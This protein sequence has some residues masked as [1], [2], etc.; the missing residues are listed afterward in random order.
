VINTART[1]IDTM[2]VAAIV[3]QE[4]L[5]LEPDL[6]LYEGANDF[7]PRPQLELAAQR[8][9]WS[10]PPAMRSSRTEGFSA[11]A[12][13]LHAF[14]ARLERRDGS[15]PRKPAYPIQWPAEVDEW[16]PDVTQSAL[17]MNLKSVLDRFDAMRT[18]TDKTGG[19]FGVASPVRMVR[20]GLK[21]TLP[22]DETLY[23][24]LNSYYPLTY[25]QVKRLSDFQQRVFR[26]YAARYDLLYLDSAAMYPLD[27]QLFADAV[28]MTPA[29]LRLKAWI[30]LQL[31]IPWL[32]RE[33]D[34]GHLPRPMQHPQAVH[35]AFASTSYP[36]VSKAEILASCH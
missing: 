26:A 35:P 28:H 29:G 2:S 23:N 3:D 11:L 25:A 19:Q 24:F 32:E 4:V 13:R 10:P 15:E 18:A 9:A 7:G 17:P 16:H 6:V 22:A 34:S 36:L 14:V 8:L 21:L 33:I 12:R 27:P 1:G 30:D 20:D 31:L 5:P